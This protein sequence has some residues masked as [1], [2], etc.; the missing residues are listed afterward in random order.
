MACSPDSTSLEC[1]LQSSIDGAD[2]ASIHGNGIGD[3]AV[4]GEVR[5]KSTVLI[6]FKL[7]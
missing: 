1:S 2:Q 6:F 4:I 5:L 3:S 7:K